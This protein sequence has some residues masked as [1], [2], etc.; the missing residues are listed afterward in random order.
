M[1]IDLVFPDIKKKMPTTA[2]NIILH[3]VEQNPI[4][5]KKRRC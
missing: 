5:R 4:Y 3:K 2:R 1:I